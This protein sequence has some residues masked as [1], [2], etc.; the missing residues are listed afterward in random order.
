MAR[1][2]LNCYIEDKETGC[3]IWQGGRVG[4]NKD[5]GVVYSGGVAIRAHRYFY[6]HKYGKIPDGLFACHKCDNPICCNPDHI[7]IGTHQDNMRDAQEKKRFFH[8]RKTHCKYGHEYTEENTCYS[9]GGRHC[10]A[11]MK[12]RRDMRKATGKPADPVIE[13][14]C[15]ACGKKFQAVI[16]KLKMGGMSG[17]G[18]SAKCSG[19]LRRG[20]NYFQRKVNDMSKQVFPLPKSKLTWC[21]SVRKKDAK[22]DSEEQFFK[23]KDEAFKAAAQVKSGTWQLFKLSYEFKDCWVVK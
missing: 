21:L 20:P 6:E 23:S 5:Y 13:K 15:E 16:R 12:K 9:N 4:T 8:Q 19:V 11:C 1:D 17:R 18:C 3:W 2:N 14:I 7:F 10:L 22:K